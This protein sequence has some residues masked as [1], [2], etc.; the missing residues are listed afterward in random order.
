MTPVVNLFRTVP[1]VKFIFCCWLN[2]WCDCHVTHA[3][4]NVMSQPK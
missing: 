3:H 1:S 2:P 4:W